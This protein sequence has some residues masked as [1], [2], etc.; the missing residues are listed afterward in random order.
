M[1]GSKIKFTKQLDTGTSLAQMN[2]WLFDTTIQSEVKSGC[3]DLE[4][5]F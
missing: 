5:V 2:E 1:R 4:Y 3:V